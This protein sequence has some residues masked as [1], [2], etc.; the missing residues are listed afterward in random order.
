M[1]V[2]LDSNVLARA[3]Y[4]VGGPAEECVRR[5]SNAPHVLV[6]SQFLLDELS[7]VLRY[8]RLHR[9]HGFDDREIERVVAALESAAARVQTR[10]E[11][12][13]PIVP[14]DPDDDPIVAAAIA[15]GADILCTRNRHLYH[16]VVVAYCRQH[17]V[18]ILDDI[19]LLARLRKMEE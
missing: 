3:F 10:E 15:G 17:A 14:H 19:E 13:V 18:E 4:S 11:N 5:L 2:L 8:P 1:R 7:R 16:E 9:V 6:V 12:L